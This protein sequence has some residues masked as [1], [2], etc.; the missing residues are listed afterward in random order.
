MSRVKSAFI[1]LLAS[2]DA[3]S[4]RTIFRP[5]NNGAGRI[6]YIIPSVSDS[7]EWMTKGIRQ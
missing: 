3:L 1:A 2:F 7:I 6:F 5:H 4:D